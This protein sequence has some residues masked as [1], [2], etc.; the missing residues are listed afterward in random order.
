MLYSVKIINN[1]RTAFEWFAGTL[2]DAM[3]NLCF[4]H[5][6]RTR[7]DKVTFTRMAPA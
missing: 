3:L 4:A 7:S 1:G 2:D 6:I 5:S